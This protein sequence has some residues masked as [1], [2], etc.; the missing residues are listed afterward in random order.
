VLKEGE[1][2]ARDLRDQAE[3]VWVRGAPLIPPDVYREQGSASNSDT[4][5]RLAASSTVLASYA[6]NRQSSV[7][8][9]SGSCSGSDAAEHCALRAA[10]E[11]RLSRTD[12]D[13]LPTPEVSHV[14]CS[15]DNRRQRTVASILREPRGTG[16]PA[17]AVLA[18]HHVG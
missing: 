11:V 13:R 10:C 14:D 15:A 6:L 9:W 7:W 16:R 5:V 2:L 1:S 4:S 17:D 3:A 12:S 18:A 8:S